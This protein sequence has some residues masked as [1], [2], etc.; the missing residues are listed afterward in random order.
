MSCSRSTGGGQSR[1]V[2][3]ANP[4]TTKPPEAKADGRYPIESCIIKFAGTFDG[5][6]G[7]QTVQFDRWGNREFV[8][9]SVEG[10]AP[11]STL[12]IRDADWF[13]EIDLIAKTG[14]RIP[15]KHARNSSGI[16]I[17]QNAGDRIGSEIIAGKE[18]EKWSFGEG[19]TL[20][21]WNEIPLK[22]QWEKDGKTLSIS[23]AVEVLENAA[24]PEERFEIPSDATIKEITEP[25]EVLKQLG[26]Q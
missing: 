19:V 17:L 18:C 3:A 6:E 25:G 21:I 26:Y 11:A 15:S 13:T 9:R 1:E 14:T 5:A 10:K 24:I 22:H 2:R 20:W 12:T 4:T 8:T 7:S 16:D 23:T